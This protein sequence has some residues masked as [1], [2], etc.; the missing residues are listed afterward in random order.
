M[1]HGERTALSTKEKGKRTGDILFSLKGEK[2][3]GS[4]CICILRRRVI[5]GE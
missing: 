1:L 5:T 2:R 4:H 3:L